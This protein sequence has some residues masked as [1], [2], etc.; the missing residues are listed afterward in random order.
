MVEGDWVVMPSKIQSG[1]YFGEL[2]GGY[3]YEASGPD[4]CFRWREI[5]WFSSLVPRSA[6]P[7]DLL[8][9]FG[10][11]L[12]ICKVQHNDAEAR[13]KGHGL[14]ELVQAILQAEGYTTYRSPEGADQCGPEI[15]CRN[16][17]IR[18]LDR[19]QEQHVEGAGTRLL[20]RA[21]MEQEGDA[22]CTA[23]EAG[24]DG[25]GSGA[26]LSW[27]PPA[28]ANPLELCAHCIVQAPSETPSR[29]RLLQPMPGARLLQERC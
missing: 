15:Q 23:L 16:L 17:P 8:D 20:A 21:A 19:V 18:E 27:Q 6:F 9:S 13:F 14:A 7:Q 22:S 25:G 4:S 10:A 26:R 11:F 29:A 24:L 2:R 5:N 28:I 3:P 1:L 12:T